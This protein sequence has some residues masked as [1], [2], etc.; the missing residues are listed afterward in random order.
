MSRYT[1]SSA[2]LPYALAA[3]DIGSERVRRRRGSFRRR[4]GVV[5][6]GPGTVRDSSRA[7][8][9][10]MTPAALTRRR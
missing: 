7:I 6:P 4:D 8:L 5:D 2:I 10:A 3:E 1:E 9:R